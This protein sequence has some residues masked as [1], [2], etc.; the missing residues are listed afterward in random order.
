MGLKPGPGR[1]TDGFISLPVL[2]ENFHQKV[3]G[4]SSGSAKQLYVCGAW[5]GGRRLATE[6]GRGQARNGRPG[7]GGQKEGGGLAADGE[8]G[9]AQLPKPRDDQPPGAIP[10]P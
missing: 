3:P 4:A 7:Q 10:K 6:G 8:E 9:F 2:P 5:R 1:H